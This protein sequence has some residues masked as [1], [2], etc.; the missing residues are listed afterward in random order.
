MKLEK[1]L[2]ILLVFIFITTFI[3]EIP[4]VNILVFDKVWVLY[5]V[6]LFLLFFPYNVRSILF[7]IPLLLLI[8]LVATILGIDL[9]GEVVGVVV[10]TFL[11]IVGILK[12]RQLLIEDKNNK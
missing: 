3:K 1:K 10:Y 7:S 8:A 2:I 4:Y 9:V 5:P 6:L 11:W 12:V